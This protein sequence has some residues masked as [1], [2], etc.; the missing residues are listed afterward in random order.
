MALISLLVLIIWLILLLAP[1]RFW[2]VEPEPICIEPASQPEIAVVIPA[3]D[4]AQLIG[5]T[6]ESLWRQR[7]SGTLRIFL[8]DDQSADGTS[9]AGLAVA[10]ILGRELDLVIVTGAA[11]PDGWTGKVWAMNQGVERALT[12]TTAELILFSDADIHHGEGALAKL[13]CLAEAGPSDLASYMVRLQ[14]ETAAEKLMIPAFVFFFRMLYPFRRA[15][16]PNDRLAAAAGGTILL[17]RSALERIGGLAAIKGELI[18]DCSLAREVKRGGH[19]IWLGLSRDSYSTRQYSKLSEI[20]NMISRTAYTQLGY[21]PIRLLACVVGL[22]LT[23]LAPPVLTIGAKGGASLIAGLA[24]LTMSAL[25]LP[26]LRFYHRSPLWAPLL[27]ITA[28]VY[29]W[30]TVLSAWRH[31]RGTGGAWKGRVRQT[32]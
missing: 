31:Y 21:S 28:T 30:A 18:D 6:L 9:G 24:W 13:V 5:Q 11:L 4:E 19:R 26:M 27:P 32:S 29:L 3:R 23:F 12:A 25:Y 10:R 14:C 15:N 20:V 8:V 1:G 16:D 17:R 22:A 7:Y 2:R